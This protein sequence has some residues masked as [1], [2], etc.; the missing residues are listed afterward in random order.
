MSGWCCDR[1]LPASKASWEGTGV[2]KLSRVTS[3]VLVEERRGR[4]ARLERP[5]GGRP[6]SRGPRVMSEL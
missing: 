3:G 2:E 6:E 5:G 4:Q 1:E